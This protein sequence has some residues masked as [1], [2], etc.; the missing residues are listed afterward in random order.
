MRRVVLLGLACSIALAGSSPAEAALRAC[1]P[2]LRPYPGTRYDDV[3][4]T[5]VRTSTASCVTARRVARGAH[6]KA[7]RM[8]PAG[9][10]R[11]F[12]WRGW[13]VTGDLRPDRDRYVARR[14]GRQVRW[15][16]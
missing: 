5:R 9:R 4:L 6:R 7:L 1:K 8:A 12:T 16:F 10:Y 14:A 11:R 15:R 3:D 2:V 13:A